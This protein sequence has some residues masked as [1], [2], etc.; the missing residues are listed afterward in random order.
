MAVC[1]K[2]TPVAADQAFAQSASI[3][4][5]CI[6]P[7]IDA[8]RMRGARARRNTYGSSPSGRIR[9]VRTAHARQEVQCGRSIAFERPQREPL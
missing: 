7:A 5:G 8:P 4:L 9:R 6:S 3:C 1:N 2:H